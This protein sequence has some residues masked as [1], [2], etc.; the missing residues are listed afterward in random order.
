VDDGNEKNLTLEGMVITMLVG[1]LTKNTVKAAGAVAVILSLCAVVLATDPPINIGPGGMITNGQVISGLATYTTE[2]TGA[3]ITT[4]GPET[5][6]KYDRFNVWDEWN[7][8]IDQLSGSRSATLN[9]VT[10]GCTSQILGTFTSNG[11]VFLV[12]PAGIVFGAHSQMN[13]PKLVASGLNMSYDEFRE[14]ARQP[15]NNS[16]FVEFTA[17]TSGG[18]IDM[19]TDG[20]G[21]GI[22]RPAFSTDQ[23]YLIGTQVQNVATIVGT[24]ESSHPYVVMAA[25]TGRVEIRKWGQQDITVEAF[26]S[27]PTTGTLTGIVP[28]RTCGGDWPCS[29]TALGTGDIYSV[30]V[31]DTS[32]VAM[33]AQRDVHVT[34]DVESFGSIK[35]IA[36]QYLT[37]DNDVMGG[38]G[39]SGDVLLSSGADTFVG[40]DVEAGG[41][42]TIFSKRNA[43]V[44]GH[45]A[46]TNISMTAA[47]ANVVRDSVI[48]DGG[49]VYMLASG[50]VNRVDSSV[51]GNGVTMMAYTSNEV[52]GS[53][54]ATSGDVYMLAKTCDNV[55]SGNVAGTNV[56]MIAGVNNLVD[57]SVIADGGDASMYTWWGENHVV[58]GVSGNNVSMTAYMGNEVQ[59]GV[60]AVGGNVDMT[61]GMDNIVSAG[62]VEADG[63]D[64]TMVATSGMNYVAQNVTGDNVS[65]K[66][67]TNNKVGGSVRAFS[68][69]AMILA[70]WRN[71]TIGGD[72]TGT[73]VDMTAGVSN[74]VDGSVAANEGDVTMVA[75]WGKNHVGDDD[76]G[77][78]LGDNVSMWA[79]TRNEVDGSVS[80]TSGD[81]DMFAEWYDNVVVGDVSGN[82]ISM[83][84]G[85]N[86]I[87]NGDVTAVEGKVDI[88]SD[89]YTILGGNV[90]AQ[91]DVTLTAGDGVVLNSISIPGDQTIEA[92]TGTLT[93]IAPLTE[94]ITRGN[95]L[96]SGGASGLAV[97]LQT[98]V[99]TYA[100]NIEVKGVGDIQLGGYLIAGGSGE[101]P[102]YY[103]ISVISDSGEIYSGTPGSGISILIKGG[104]DQDTG[105]GVGLP[106]DPMKKAAII[107]ISNAPLKLAP[108][109][110]LIATGTYYG[111][112]ETFDDR[113][114]IKFRN[115][116]TW[117][118]M[119]IDVA[120]YAQSKSGDVTIDHLGILR[121]EGLGTA[122]LDAKGRVLLTNQNNAGVDGP[123]FLYRL[124]VCSRDTIWLS[125]AIA[126]GMLPFADNPTLM[127]PLMGGGMYV[128]RGG[129]NPE[130]IDGAWVLHDEEAPS[131]QLPTMLSAPTDDGCPALLLAAANELGQDP[132]LFRN[133]TLVNTKSMQPCNTC[134]RLMRSADVLKDPEGRRLAA[135][136]QVLNEFVSAQAPLSPE[137]MASVNQT[138]AMH[139]KDGSAYAAAQEWVDA[140]ATYVGIMKSEL[141]LSQA[142]ALAIATGR[143]GSPDNAN[144]AAKAFIAQKLAELAG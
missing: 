29:T 112:D 116:S 17:P 58:G 71:N 75:R 114:A 95:L 144:D 37:V 53:V 32:L 104:S 85:S 63:G 130:G 55:V 92:I 16:E 1:R 111:A 2:G 119:P 108:G 76:A 59:Q 117:Q 50:G 78:V 105:R 44:D 48:A 131:V 103:G 14:L 5:I 99:T 127:Q 19:L 54:T 136:G 33:T 140:L 83:M 51:L 109:A 67:L 65:M 106:F 3:T 134:E 100:G 98:P 18:R 4:T 30:A 9:K 13:M 115:A 101:L 135:L 23:L 42:V 132:A 141:G 11:Q 28:A 133:G 118:G 49:N 142:D 113:A 137:Q 79:S 38:I 110:Q 120:I 36:R 21:D 25:A 35:L 26:T 122:A 70:E 124:E 80:A 62:G 8:R 125:E 45:I 88:Y 89:N 6:I 22:S 12:N 41:N 31:V 15:V 56:D 93:I 7:V 87:V 34:G 68:G 20:E 10:G 46:G 47:G 91:T 97:D 82:N 66:A 81:V 138:L 84:A 43:T 96:L 121:V 74:L 24:S 39:T 73:N 126:G 139:A 128:L 60:T 102:L 129:V 52:D 64:V 61:A 77:D 123:Y 86:N 40:G 107:L 94:K 143:Y 72:V 27:P 57:V 90:E 69:D